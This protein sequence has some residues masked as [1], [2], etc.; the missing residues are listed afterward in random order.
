[1]STWTI[2]TILIFLFFIFAPS[3]LAIAVEE[4][5]EP[6][7]PTCSQLDMSEALNY[8]VTIGP[9]ISTASF[10]LNWKNEASKIKMDLQTP[11]GPMDKI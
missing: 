7:I 10:A 11:R 3:T 2:S 4:N 9:D 6:D 5:I 8:T 1:M